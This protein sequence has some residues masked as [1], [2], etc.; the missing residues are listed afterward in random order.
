MPLLW[1]FLFAVNLWRA[2]GSDRLRLGV[3]PQRSDRLRL[4]VRLRRL[5]LC[6]ARVDKPLIALNAPLALLQDAEEVGG[7][8]LLCH[9]VHEHVLGGGPSDF[10]MTLPLSI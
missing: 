7:V 6:G 4:G 10:R 9:A 8:E 1:A 3:L 2:C 5:P